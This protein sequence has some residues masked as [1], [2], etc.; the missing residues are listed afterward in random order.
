MVAGFAAASRAAKNLLANDDAEWERLRP[1][2]K[3]ADDAA[4]AALKAGFRAGIP[5]GDPV[6]LESASSFLALMAE[7]GGE[8]L[9]GKANTL[10][11]GVFYRPRD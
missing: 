2:M 9:V 3:A 6:N 1:H 7:M 5:S 4:F 11:E 8:K 10:P